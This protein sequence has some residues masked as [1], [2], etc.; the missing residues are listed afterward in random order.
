MKEEKNL[1]PIKNEGKSVKPHHTAEFKGYDLDELRY[2]RAVVALK[3]E[4]AKEKVMA[5]VADI[6]KRLPF[7]KSHDSKM[8]FPMAKGVLGKVFSG[9]N[10]VDY[11]LLGFSV[12][13]TGR[14]VFS[15]F[16]KKK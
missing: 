2:Q 8:G 13:N 5:D 14:K 16:R 7:N 12:I 9:L 11:F 6:K 3:K 4:F 10:Y 15:F 1:T